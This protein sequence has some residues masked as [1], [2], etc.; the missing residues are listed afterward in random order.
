MGRKLLLID[1]ENI[2]NFD[3]TSLPG[4]VD[5]VIFVGARQ[6][7]TKIPLPVIKAVQKLGARLEW[8]RTEGSGPNALDFHIA[9]HL[10]RVFEKQRSLECY[11]LSQDRGFDPLLRHLCK[12]GLKCGRICDLS[13]LTAGLLSVKEANY[14]RVAESLGKVPKNSR[15]RKRGTLIG[16]IQSRFEKNLTNKEVDA[17]IARLKTNKL[18]TETNGTISYG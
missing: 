9:C 14:Q 5:V 4:D 16:H 13:G 18:L 10:G 17:I 7:K 2:Q 1:F 12:K 6:T 15:P 8:Q 11:V 3:L